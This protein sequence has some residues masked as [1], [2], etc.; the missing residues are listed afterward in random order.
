MTKRSVLFGIV[1]AGVSVSVMAQTTNRLPAMVVT[2]TREESNPLEVPATTHSLDAGTVQVERASRTTPDVFEGIPSVMIQ[3][4]GHA[5][6][7]PFIRGFTGFRTLM[8]VDGIRLNNSVFRDGPNQ[9]WSTIDSLSVDRFELAMG[10]S[11]VLYGSDAIGGTAQALTIA[12]PPDNQP[13]WERSL[14]ARG[15]S[16]EES[17]AGRAQVRGRIENGIGF[18][19]GVSLKTYGDLH[20]GKDVGT[21]EKTGYDEQAYDIKVDHRIGEKAR[22]TL[23]H[24]NVQ[25]DDAWRTHRTIYGISEWEGLTK[26]DDQKHIFDQNRDLTYARFDATDLNGFVNSASL[27]ISRHAQGEDLYRL[28]KD[29]A[30]D[31]QGFDVETWGATLQL[32]SKTR[33]GNFVYGAEY[34]RDD[35]QSYSHKIT[36]NGTRKVDPQGPIAD[37]STYETIGVFVQDTISLFG[38]GLEVVPGVRYTRTEADAGKVK[39]PVSGDVVSFRNDWDAAVGSLRLLAPLTD[40]K[41]HVVFA[42]VGQGFRAPNLSDLSRFDTARSGELETPSPDLDPERFVSF[43]LGYKAQGQRLTSQISAYHT[44]ID[45]MIIRTPTGQIIDGNMEVTK[46]NSGEG[47]VQGIELLERIVLTAALS[48]WLSASWMD[49]NIEAYPTSTAAAEDTYVSRTMPLTAQTG[50][51][52]QATGK[53]LWFELLADAATKA[54]QLS[55]DDERD[56]QRIPPGGTPGYIIPTIRGGTLISDFLELSIAVENILDEDYRNHGSGVNEPGRNLVL[57][58]GCTF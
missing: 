39:D 14:Y 24:Q 20:G 29:T 36:T 57:T 18:V 34:Y 7:S 9:Y 42:G 15:A 47:Y 22:L 10:P 17:L 8:L 44:L 23:A 26:G 51:R 28:R 41:R 16:A 31:W 43:E 35:V 5:Q 49:T 48:V 53:P 19:A 56:T 37:D 45:D 12:P 11:S 4:T 55:P 33:A 52:W 54:T 1:L 2:A 50:I 40:D 6:G 3:K 38:G 58:A 46:L 21:Q 30:Q 13:G 32:A 25:Q 27:T